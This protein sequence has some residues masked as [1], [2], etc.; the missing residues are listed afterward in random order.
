MQTGKAHGSIKL[1]QSGLLTGIEDAG[2]AV[3]NAVAGLFGQHVDPPPPLVIKE[4]DFGDQGAL[5]LWALHSPLWHSTAPRGTA[6]PLMAQHSTLWHSTVPCGP[7]QHEQAG[8][9]AADTCVHNTSV[10][11]WGKKQKIFLTQ[12]V[13]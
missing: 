9:A 11:A 4:W 2:T 7:A 10:M 8:H 5:L 12:L 1:Q 3:V 6:Q 13:V